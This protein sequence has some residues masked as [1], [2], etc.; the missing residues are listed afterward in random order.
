MSDLESRHPRKQND[1]DRDMLDLLRARQEVSPGLR[2]YHRFRS[3]ATRCYRSTRLIAGAV[4]A[5][6]RGNPTYEDALSDYRLRAEPATAGKDAE[7]PAPAR[8]GRQR[9]VEV[10]AEQLLPHLLVVPA[11][12]RTRLSPRTSAEPCRR[13]P[14]TTPPPSVR[15]PG[16][17]QRRDRQP[18]AA[19]RRVPHRGSGRVPAGQTSPPGGRGRLL[20]LGD[21]MKLPTA[22]PEL[23]ST[24]AITTS[25]IGL[26]V[27]QVA[28]RTIANASCAPS[29]SSACSAH[30]GG[31]LSRSSGSVTRSSKCHGVTTRVT[32]CFG[33]RCHEW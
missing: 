6:H 33:G 28:T 30:D 12:P 22:G 25:Q 26:V 3:I 13:R 29:R 11:Q 7:P 2:M 5:R 20:E 16:R 24:C 14:V 9:A 1:L 19:S 18:P 15:P 4:G 17:S 8:T 10:P 23:S 21:P 31:S 32:E 27:R